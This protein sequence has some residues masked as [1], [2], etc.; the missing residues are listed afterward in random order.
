MHNSITIRLPD[1]MIQGIDEICREQ[2]NTRQDVIRNALSL[3]L[4]NGNRII[5][6]NIIPHHENT[7]PKHNSSHHKAPSISDSKIEQSQKQISQ[8]KIHAKI[9]AIVIED[10]TDMKD[11]FV[12]I[13]KMNNITVIGTGSNGKEAAELYEKLHPDVVFMDIIMPT[14]DGIHGINEIKKIDPNAKI[15]LVTGAAIDVK[16]NPLYNTTQI[17][18]KPIDMKNIMKAVDKIM[19]TS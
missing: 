8:D 18:P 2:Q 19:I 12:E 6:S 9:H 3:M 14:Y 11:V 7:N 17:V 15:I 4:F 13:L 5:E 16:K 10:D 1:S